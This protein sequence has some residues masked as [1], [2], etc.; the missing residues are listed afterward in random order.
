VTLLSAARRLRVVALLLGLAAML[1]ATSRAQMAEIRRGVAKIVVTAPTS[2]TGAGIVVRRGADGAFIVTA[3]HVVSGA[4]KIVVQ[5]FG[6]ARSWPAEVRNIE[7]ENVAQGL[8]LLRVA[9]LLP[10]EVLALPLAIEVTASGGE[11]VSMI[12]HQRSTG[13][14]G[15]L[16]GNVSGRKGREIV[17]QAPIQEQTS[18]GPVILGGHVIGLVQRR[19]PSGAFGYAVTAH[20]IWEYVQGLQVA[21][22]PLPSAPAAGEAGPSPTKAPPKVATTFTPGESFRECAQCP[23]VV[24]IP[25]GEFTMGSPQGEAGRKQDE[26]PPHKVTLARPFAVG[27]YEVTFAE[28]DACMAAGGCVHKPDDHGWGRDRWPVINVNWEDVQAYASWLSKSTGKPYRLL[29]EAEWEYAARAGTTTRYPWGDAPGINRANFADSAS[30][31][32]GKQTAPTGSFAANQF[33]L[34]DMIGNVWEWVQDCYGSYRDALRD[35]R[36]VEMYGCTSRVLRGG[37]WNR[38]PEVARAANRGRA[39]PDR[40]GYVI[41][42]RVARTL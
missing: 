15:M 30:Y 7:V 2:K 23:E 3:A 11:Q 16:A 19:D 24:V 20:A 39:E 12:G 8:A 4:D 21:L 36:A 22:A 26:D 13:D 14:W 35:G 29:S 17:I 28:W 34:H 40:R 6:V 37:G 42:F 9:D 5:F 27:K 10:T 32:S 38:L 33:G 18:G 31:W 1:P 41:G 25:A